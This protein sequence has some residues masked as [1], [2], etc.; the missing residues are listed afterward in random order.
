MDGVIVAALDPP[1]LCEATERLAEIL[2]ACVHEAALARVGTGAAD[3]RGRFSGPVA[4]G[5]EM[6]SVTRSRACGAPR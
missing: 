1:G 4:I 6:C 3:P 5:S 2:H